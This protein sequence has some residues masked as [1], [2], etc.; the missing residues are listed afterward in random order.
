MKK[1]Q[2][3]S[4]RTM[5]TKRGQYAIVTGKAYPSIMKGQNPTRVV[6]SALNNRETFYRDPAIQLTT[7]DLDALDGAEGAPMCVEHNKKDVVG[8]IHHTYIDADDPEKGWKIMARIPLND[9]G[10]RVVADIKAG[11]LN[12]FSV[13][14][15]NVLDRDART[16]IN[17]LDFK[18]FREISLV[19][20]P[21]FDGCNLS[22]SV[23]A[24]KNDPGKIYGNN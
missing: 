22:V 4:V 23:T 12:G 14:Y 9:R 21:F 6:Q 18:E 10:K 19:N 20:E 1:Q 7:S 16:G 5:N 17:K 3:W 8:S 13:G 2:P 15:G 11:K 24:S